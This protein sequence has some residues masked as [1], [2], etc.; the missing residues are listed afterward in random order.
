MLEWLLTLAEEEQ[1]SLDFQYRKRYG[2]ALTDPRY[3]DA[4]EE[5]MNLDLLAH[6]M[7]QQGIGSAEMGEILAMQ[8]AAENGEAKPFE[9]EID[10]L[11][12]LVDR[13]LEKN[14]EAWEEDIG[15]G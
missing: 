3:L 13:S 7:D 6:A 5:Q 4:S 9:E 11:Q 15:L 12:R 2:L 10:F 8:Q 1:D 14:P